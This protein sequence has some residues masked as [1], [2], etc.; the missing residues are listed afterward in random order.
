MQ[1]HIGLITLFGKNL[2]FEINAPPEHYS[3][4]ILFNYQT[5]T[6]IWEWSLGS[7]LTSSENS[8]IRLTL[9]HMNT[10]KSQQNY[11]HTVTKFLQILDVQYTDQMIITRPKIKA[12]T[13]RTW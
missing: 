7:I 13:K 9:K 11:L 1:K 5:N 3:N 4:Y 8:L 6:G 2:I 10:D 12:L